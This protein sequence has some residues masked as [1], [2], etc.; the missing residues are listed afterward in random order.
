[1]ET[2]ALFAVGNKIGIQVGAVLAVHGNRVTD[3]WLEDYEP[4]QKRLIAVAC[5]ALDLLNQTV[6]PGSEHG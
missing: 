4:A 1:M 3:Q 2:E 5:K 6:V